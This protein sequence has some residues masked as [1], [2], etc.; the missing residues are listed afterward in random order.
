MNDGMDKITPLDSCRMEEFSRPASR[1]I[2]ARVKQHR[3]YHERPIQ[4]DMFAEYDAIAAWST[5]TCCYSGIEQSM[6]CLLEMRGIIDR[7]THWLGKLFRKLAPEEQHVLRFSY[8]IYRSLHNHILPETVEI[9]LDKID[10]GYSQSEKPVPGYNTWRYFLLEGKMPPTTHPGAMLEIWSALS[11]ILQARV[12]TNH[13][14]ESVDT[15]VRANLNR[16][17]G[18]DPYAHVDLNRCIDVSIQNAESKLNPDGSAQTYENELSTLIED[19]AKFVRDGV[20]A[21][22]IDNDLVYFVHRAQRGELHWNSDTELFE[23]VSRLEKIRI[24]LVVT[25]RSDVESFVLGPSVEVETIEKVPKYIEEF[26]F[27]PRLEGD[28]DDADWTA[29]IDVERVKAEYEGRMAEIEEY[30][31]GNECEAYDCQVGRM[32]LIIVLYDSREWIIFEHNNRNVPGVPRHCVHIVGNLRSLREAIGAI[33]QWR[34]TQE[35]EVLAVHKQLWNCRGKRRTEA[36]R[37]C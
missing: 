26:T 7:K 5:V 35:G 20:R 16:R 33:E 15:R 30:L 31:G 32:R 4:R 3:S 27:E 2:E 23:K 8:A 14:L 17:L 10:Q 18:R 22:W 29:E 34:K 11:D 19:V 9:F 36:R 21:K 1:L 6:K 12:F 37:S 24:K 25:E 13:G 28:Y